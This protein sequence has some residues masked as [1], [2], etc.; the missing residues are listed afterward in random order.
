MTD[1]LRSVFVEADD[2]YIASPRYSIK[3]GQEGRAVNDYPK[4]CEAILQEGYLESQNILTE[5]SKEAMIA[6][7]HRELLFAQRLTRKLRECFLNDERLQDMRDDE[8]N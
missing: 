6:V 4:F 1:K 7:V 3:D 8:K 5:P 2:R